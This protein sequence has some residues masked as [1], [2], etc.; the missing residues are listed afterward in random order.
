MQL[1]N[2]QK[3]IV[4]VSSLVVV[5]LLVTTIWSRPGFL[6]K[7]PSP[8]EVQIAK[9]KSDTELAEYKKYLAEVQAD[10]R[11]SYEIINSVIDKDQ[12]QA[13]ITQD[14][15]ANKPPINPKVDPSKFRV[16]SKADTEAVRAYVTKIDGI[17]ADYNAI[18][19]DMWT[20]VSTEAPDQIVAKELQR[21]FTDTIGKLYTVDV[22][23]PVVGLH[24][25]IVKSLAIQ[26]QLIADATATA[27]GI[28]PRGAGRWSNT[29]PVFRAGQLEKEQ[30]QDALD[31]LKRDY[32]EVFSPA[33]VT[34]ASSGFGIKTANAF[35]VTIAWDTPRILEQILRTVIGQVVLN[36]IKHHV[37]NFVTR[38]D[39]DH[40][41]A[42][43]MY[44]NDALVGKNV[45][46]YVTKF[47]SAQDGYDKTDEK[48]IKNLIPRLNCGRVDEEQFKKDIRAKV[49]EHVGFDPSQ[50][51][52]LDPNDPDYYVKLSKTATL[53]GDPSGRGYQLFYQSL[54]AVA[55]GES[56][57]SA[58]LEQVSGGKKAGFD[59][60]NTKR[61]VQS[62]D[63]ISSKITAAV[64]SVFNLA[65]S[66]A[67]TGGPGW[68][69]VVTGIMVSVLSQLA[70]KGTVTLKE[71]TACIKTPTYNA[72]IPGDFTPNETSAEERTA[73]QCVR[74][75]S[76]CPGYMFEN[77]NGAGTIT[78]IQGLNPNGNPQYT[79]GTAK[80]G[81]Y[82]VLYG[83]FA[84]T[85]NELVST[86]TVGGTIDYQ[87]DTQINVKLEPGTG[88]ATF[89]IKNDNGTTNAKS[90]TVQ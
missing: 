54:S 39:K 84:E 71:A 23:Q 82:V 28:A 55:A 57:K 70:I 89:A 10:P 47:V 46:D 62:V 3:V 76:T 15:G 67:T 7:P 11:A 74:N 65:P 77:P 14:L 26:G 40:T 5:A 4:V 85:G 52:S 73:E 16:S 49:L 35:V 79:N 43:F 21:R 30:M 24:T 27:G 68:S 53:R 90:I 33:S 81:T 69:A 19:T 22:P 13:Q 1:A 51:N 38:F 78:G 60:N 86:G 66:N 64:N 2:Q 41:I 12:L 88:T 45:D 75:P 36:Y 18:S 63:L 48:M 56:E 29:Y 17:V 6:Y 44:Y 20:Q 8:D 42:N 72:V 87:S 59:A 80:S 61:I 37:L 31:V 58:I 9:Q 50:V 25:S 83:A 32:A 34:D